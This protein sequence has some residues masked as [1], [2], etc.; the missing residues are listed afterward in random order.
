MKSLHV[1]LV[2]PLLSFILRGEFS[3]SIVGA[4]LVGKIPKG[5]SDG[6]LEGAENVQG[7]F[8]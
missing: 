2:P 1:S 3:H 6:S 4:M 8:E 7:Q 5:T